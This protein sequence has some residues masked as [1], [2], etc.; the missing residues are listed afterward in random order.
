M[1]HCHVLGAGIV[2]ISCALELQCRGYQVTLVDRRGPGEETSSGNAG[3]LSYSNVMPL[4]SPALW[5]RMHLLALNLDNDLRLHYPHLPSLL[6]WLL[7]FLWR[8]RRQTY[9]R[10]GE[11]MAVLTRASIELHE[12]WIAEAGAEGL[13]NRSGGLKLYRERDSFERDALERE[14]FERCGIR[15]S[16]L[17]PERIYELEPDLKR[18]FVRGVLI[19]DTISIRDPRKLCRAY[20]NRFVE[21]G[22]HIK[23][24]AAKSLLTDGRGWELVTDR[25]KEH[26]ERLVIC[27][28]AWTPE[29]IGELGYRNPLAIERGYHSLVAPADDKRLSR[30][31]FDVDCGYVMS[32]MEA[33]YR[34]TSGSNIV[35]RDTRPDPRQ[36]ERALAHARE[37]FPV[38]RVL[39]D[40]PWMGRRPT[41]PDTLPIVGPA[42]RHRDLWLAFAHSH[43]GFTL[44]PISG[45]L[46]ANFI[47]GRE[48][49]FPTTACDPARYL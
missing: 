46:I 44:G 6:P 24:A 2:G 9:L 39:L 45:V 20:A 48:Q 1:K 12:R 47:D 43:M 14:L 4:A 15:Y 49:P 5:R 16:L 38:D 36:L 27:L 33:G 11:A 41:V 17:D 23:R 28:G 37:A 22:G 21:A 35:Y 42:P 13:A 34:V 32:P 31:V 10:D 7:R 8:C 25:G 19:E 18:I 3:I 40:E 26:A 29:I 30:P